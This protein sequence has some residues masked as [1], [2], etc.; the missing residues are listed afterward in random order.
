MACLANLHHVGIAVADVIHMDICILILISMLID[1]FVTV[2]M[3]VLMAVFMTVFMAVFM[4]VFMA[5]PMPMPMS[6][7]VAVV[8]Y[9]SL[10][11]TAPREERDLVKESNHG[12]RQH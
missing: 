7:V 9:T 6:V 4:T 10:L 11:A 5:M 12:E 2:L 3:T 1:V 8:F